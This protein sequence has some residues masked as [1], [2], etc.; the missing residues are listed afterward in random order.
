MLA[1]SLAIPASFLEGRCEGSRCFKAAASGAGRSAKEHLLLGESV[2]AADAERFGLVNR[3]VRE[4]EVLSAA[5]ELAGR[6]AAQPPLA[7]RYTKL[8]VNQ[9]LRSALLESFDTAIA[10]ELTTFRSADHAEAIEALK[11]RRPP[12]FEGR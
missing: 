8:A 5:L 7:V 9:R 3:V 4:G 2:T 11:A 6:L 10:Y 1:A 12:R